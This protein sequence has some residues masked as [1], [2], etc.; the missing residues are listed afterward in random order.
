MILPRKKRPPRPFR[1][2][3]RRYCDSL[4]TSHGRKCIFSAHRG[5]TMASFA[6]LNEEKKILRRKEKEAERQQKIKEIKAAPVPISVGKW[7]DA[8]D[9]EEV[10]KHVSDSETES[11]PE[12]AEAPVE[13]SWEQRD[14]ARP[15]PAQ[16]A[17]PAKTKKEPKKQ[18]K[19]E[20][21]D[22]DAILGELG[23]EVPEQG[24]ASASKK[25]RKK[26]EKEAEA[27]AE[28][29]GGYPAKEEKAKAKL[30]EEKEKEENGDGEEK[31]LDEAAK[32]AALEA[33][34]K[35]KAAGKKAAPSDAVKLAAAEAKKR[36]EKKTKKDKSM[37]DR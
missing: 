7:A 20:D 30:K 29:G 1:F 8:S 19:P 24:G 34:K 4:G 31:V 2:V 12:H 18:T 28:A 21:E 23:I 10:P 16:A 17:P 6:V 22:L 9:D 15:E 33:L 5:A 11:E 13:E 26:K 27:I 25:N 3:A 36:A 14:S 35:K 37:Y 32:Q